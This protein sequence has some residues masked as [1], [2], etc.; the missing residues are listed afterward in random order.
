MGK[1]APNGPFLDSQ[2]PSDIRLLPV[3]DIKEDERS[4]VGF[5]QALDLVIQDGLHLPPFQLRTLLNG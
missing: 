4:P 5:R 2:L 1:P 3:F